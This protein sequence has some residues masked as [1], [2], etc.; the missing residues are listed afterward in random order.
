MFYTAADGKPEEMAA[1]AT[2]LFL[3]IKLEC[4]QCHDHPLAPYTQEQFWEFAAFFGEFTPLSPVSPSFIGPLPPQFDR[5]RISI[6]SRTK[7]IEKVVEA[8]YFDEA[9]IA[10]TE[11][12]SPRQELADWITGPGEKYFAR[13]VANRL[14]A[15][16]FG[17]GLIDPVDESFDKNPP[18]HPELLDEL[19]RG[20][21]AAKY[22]LRV[23][24]RAITMSR[25]YQLTSHLTHPTQT[26]PKQFARM[27]LKGL[28]GAM[29]YDSLVSATG[30]RPNADE[31]RNAGR[32]FDQG[33]RSTF[34]TRFQQIGKRTETP[35]SILQALMLMNGRFVTDMTSLEKGDV[36]AAITEASF[37]DTPAKIET[38]YLAALNRKPTQEESE[39]YASY[40]DRG[41]PSN[42]QKKALADVFWVLLNST[43]F[44]FN[45]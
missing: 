24:M 43:E 25:A 12:K 13:N 16:F 8:K 32:P 39:R 34:M 37:L 44:L 36:L 4:A 28:S 26:D 22:D 23:L 6:P 19:T 30:Y 31:A 15:H 5:N 18:S 21:I 35:T 2:R 1:A 45:H 40:V 17:L 7:A 38:L 27:N 11:K 14:W 9:P 3:G 33:M 20:L 29:V 42:D 41:G 10:W